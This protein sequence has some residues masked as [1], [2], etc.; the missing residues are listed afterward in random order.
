MHMGRRALRD[1]HGEDIMWSFVTSYGGAQFMKSHGMG[2]A[3]FQLSCPIICTTGSYGPN[4]FTS[5]I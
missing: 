4:Q 1:R 5:I 3:L 2:G